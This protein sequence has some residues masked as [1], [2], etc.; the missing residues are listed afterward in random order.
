LR[1]R[2]G[3]SKNSLSRQG[4]AGERADALRASLSPETQQAACQECPKLSR[5]R[6]SILQIIPRLDTGGAELA[7][8]EIADALVRAGARAL[9]LAESGRLA[10]RLAAAGGELTAFPAATKN[11]LRILA[12]GRAIAR[13]AA[14]GGIDIIHARSRAPAWSALFAARRAGAAFVTTYHGAYAEENA[15]K[16]AYNSVMARGDVV[17]ANSRFTASLIE[18]R[19]H[20][21]PSRIAVIHRGIEPSRFDPER[22]APERVAALRRRWGAGAGERIILNAAR[23]TSW[24][25]QSVLIAAARRLAAAGRLAGVRVICAGDA[26]GRDGYTLAL[27]KQIDAGGL[28]ASVRLVGHEDDMA[29]AYLA[30]HLTVVA[31]TRAEAFGRAAIE[32]AAMGCPVVATDLGA[33]PET[34]LAEPGTDGGAT[35]GWLVPAGDAGALAARLLEAL[36]LSSAAREEMGRRARRHVL[37]NFTVGEMQ[38]R[39]LAVY[40][41]LL[42]SAL[43]QRFRATGGHDPATS[44]TR[45]S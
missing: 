5:D 44:L 4:A 36:S 2:L 12:N 24:K 39:T 37:S 33:P 7:V 45:Q 16:R 21:P 9:V 25:G 29:A 17:I 19:Y 31:S 41:R 35:T 3:H 14:G 11:P 34:I 28:G 26:Q 13:L 42:G 20:T 27:Q 10:A 1:S 43:E 30:A 8:I 23:L 18:R 40:D 15:V 22:V 6:P 32:A 38:R